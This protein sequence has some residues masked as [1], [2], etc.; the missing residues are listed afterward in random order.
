M[1]EHAVI[2]M[3]YTL[4]RALSMPAAVV[5]GLLGKE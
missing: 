3:V 2:S 5:A 1:T 4:Q